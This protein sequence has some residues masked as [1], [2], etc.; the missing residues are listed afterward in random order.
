MPGT[1]SSAANTAG[2]ISVENGEILPASWNNSR[3]PTLPHHASDF[4]SQPSTSREE[5]R[6]IHATYVYLAVIVLSIGTVA[7]YFIPLP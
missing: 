7:S 1:G 4:S 5:R 3:A 6:M 2:R